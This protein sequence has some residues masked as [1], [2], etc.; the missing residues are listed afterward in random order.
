MKPSPLTLVWLLER[1]GSR[2][3]SAEILSQRPDGTTHRYTYRDVH[4]RARALAAALQ[5][6]GLRR[7]DRV[8]T[9]M[10]NHH[11]HLEAYFGVPVVGGVLHTLDPF[12][13]AG[14]L[15]YIVNHAADRFLI[16]DDVLLPVFEKFRG[17]VDIEQVIVVPVKG[18]YAGHGYREYEDLLQESSGDPRYADLDEDE[19]AGVIY[20]GGTSGWPRPIVYSHGTLAFH[21]YSISLPDNFSIRRGDTILSAMSMSHAHAWGLPYA[22]LL[23]GSRI[24]LPGP[25]L[26]AERILEL[27]HEHQVT[28]M[29]AG[30]T[31]WL[32]V[33]DALELEPERWRQVRGTRVVVGGP[34]PGTLF[35]R[36]DVFGVRIVEPW[37]IAGCGWP[38]SVEDERELRREFRDWSEEVESS[39]GS[40]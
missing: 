9:L 34:A 1:A 27:L 3:P 4:V 20:T 36:L 16:V 28:L 30:P 21:A 26:Q 18:G 19:P 38:G 33:L 39:A 12:L 37:G 6:C 32:D 35:R 15:A 13:V 22:A 14:D 10:W 8:A 11:I 24:V 23:Q 2:F 7:G 5:E 31:M 17:L 29:A 40:G 25:S